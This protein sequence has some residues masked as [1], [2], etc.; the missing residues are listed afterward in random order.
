MPSPLLFK[1]RGFTLFE[2]LLVIGIIAV[3]AAIVIL[4]I[5]PRRQLAQARDAQRRAD[6]NTI[7]NAIYQYSIDNDGIFPDALSGSSFPTSSPVPICKGHLRRG[8]TGPAGETCPSG[9]T[10]AVTLRSISGT[11]MVSVPADPSYSGLTSTGW[12][13]Y[14]IQ[15]LPNRRIQVS[16][17]PETPGASTITVTR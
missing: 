7:I 14:Y 15:K 17:T 13:R 16:A 1:R 3:L 10:G 4:S 9:P 12:T 5:N 11:Y 6:V 2:L 8:Q